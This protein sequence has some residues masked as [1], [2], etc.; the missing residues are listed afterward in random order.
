MIVL[1]R[2]ISEVKIEKDGN[3]EIIQSSMT[4]STRATPT[5]IVSMTQ[6]F[7]KLLVLALGLELT[8][9]SMKLSCIL[10]CSQ[11]FRHRGR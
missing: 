9:K 10:L 1:D 6:S 8:F 4:G 11:S 3:V 7:G 5:W 2:R